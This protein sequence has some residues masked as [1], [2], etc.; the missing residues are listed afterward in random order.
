MR[1]VYQG[2][3]STFPYYR[4][5][6]YLKWTKFPWN[7]PSIFKVRMEESSHSEI[8]VM[9]GG[10]LFLRTRNLPLFIEYDDGWNTDSL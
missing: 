4:G 3:S 6:D 9:R 10:H 5:D 1:F 8:F 2:E 7:E